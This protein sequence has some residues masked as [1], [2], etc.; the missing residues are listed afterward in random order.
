MT[1]SFCPYCDREMDTG[2]A[3]ARRTKDHVIPRLLGGKTIVF[4]C[5]KCNHDKAALPPSEWHHLLQR[6]GDPRATHV[7]RFLAERMREI[8]EREPSWSR[9]D[10][11]IDL[12]DGPIG[13]FHWG[14]DGKA[15]LTPSQW[16]RA[17]A[18]AKEVLRRLSR[19]GHLTEP[20]D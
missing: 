18:V 6:A 2:A 19:A 20:F 13:G 14:H 17:R 3:D 10:P 8:E 12:I 9:E 1:P 5:L 4:A 7:A 16:I 15:R 11:R